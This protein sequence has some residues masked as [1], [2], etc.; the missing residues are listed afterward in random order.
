[1]VGT[2]L[3]FGVDC[4]MA[5]HT[6]RSHNPKH[7]IPALTYETLN[8]KPLRPEFPA[9]VMLWERACGQLG[10]CIESGVRG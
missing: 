5:L 8:P 10:V 7:G 3:K 4:S 1:M 2:G 9:F 6:A